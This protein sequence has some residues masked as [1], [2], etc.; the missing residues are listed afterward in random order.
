MRPV[1]LLAALLC[2]ALAVAGALFA[3]DVR[4][5]S[6]AMRD[7]DVR[8]AAGG[9]PAPEWTAS[10]TL[11]AGLSRRVLDVDDDRALREAALGFRRASRG[12]N[13]ILR[14]RRDRAIAESLLLDVASSGSSTQGSQASNLLGVLTFADATSGR[15][16]ATP[17]E[18]T[19]SAFREAVRLDP[20]N[21][22]A[23]TNLELLLRLIQARGSRLGPNPNPGPR[24][25]GRHGA[26]TGAPGR[27]Y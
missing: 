7:G 9:L 25:T 8:Y 14:K 24:G 26:G 11:P 5:W 23:K 22:D 2:A 21:A 18:R 1:R 6:D 17:V 12:S 13:D 15:R 20:D 19:V 10:T 3:A 16:A 4:A 27:G